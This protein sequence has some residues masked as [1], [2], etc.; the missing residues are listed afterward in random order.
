MDLSLEHQNLTSRRTECCPN[1][2]HN[3]RNSLVTPGKSL[4]RLRK[5]PERSNI[6]ESRDNYKRLNQPKNKNNL[7]IEL[8][9][10]IRRPD[11]DRSDKL[12][13][14]LYY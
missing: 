6:G 3:P 4:G 1:T 2:P 12:D 11:M 5:A 8:R 9:T 14:I 13:L 10:W 7:E